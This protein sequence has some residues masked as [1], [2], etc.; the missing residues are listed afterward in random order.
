MAEREEKTQSLEAERGY[1]G[2]GAGEH[3]T[4][5]WRLNVVRCPGFAFRCAGTPS[6]RRFSS[7]NKSTL[8]NALALKVRRSAVVKAA[9]LHR[10]SREMLRLSFIVTIDIGK[11]DGRQ[12]AAKMASRHGHS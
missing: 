12:A 1:F 10:C 8:G 9:T 5:T 3:L 7:R 2:G 6:N 4:Q 11:E